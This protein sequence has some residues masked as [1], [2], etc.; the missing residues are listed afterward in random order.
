MASG[1]RVGVEADGIL[2]KQKRGGGEEGGVMDMSL[3]LSLLLG[4]R[5]PEPSKKAIDEERSGGAG[6]EV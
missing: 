3:S 6:E 2:P 4:R 1:K 5:L